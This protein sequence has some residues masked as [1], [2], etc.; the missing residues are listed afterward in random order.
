MA[1]FPTGN[2]GNSVA[3]PGPLPSAPPANP[4]DQAAER[5]GQIAFGV[6]TESVAQETAQQQ[7]LY[8]AGA[9]VALSGAQNQL[10]DASDDVKRRIADGSLSTEEA[11]AEFKKAAAKVRETAFKGYGDQQRL[12]M[13]AHITG[14]EGTIGRDINGAIFKRRQTETASFIDQY[15]EEQS[16][17]AMRDP[18]GPSKATE[19]VRAM[20]GFAGPAAN[21]NPAQQA[22]LGQSFAERVHA[23]FYERAGNAAFMKSDVPSLQAL[24]AQVAGPDGEVLD[25]TKRTQI[26][27][28]LFT[29]EQQIQA[30]AAHG[31]DV[32]DK[33]ADDETTSARKF[34]TEGGVMST[35]YQDRLRMLTKGTRWQ[36]EAEGLIDASI[37][38]AG[39]GSQ[40]VPRQAAMLSAMSG[41]PMSPEQSKDL[42][43]ARTIHEKQTAAYKEDPWDAGSRFQRLPLVAAQPV[44]GVGQLL[45]MAT[46]RVPMMPGLEAA[47]G[48]PAPLLRPAEVPQAIQQLQSASIRERTEVL[49][50]LGS[51]LKPNQIAALADQLE[52]GSKPLALTLKMSTDKTTAG[53]MASEL[54]QVGAQAL[55][56]KTVKRDDSA[57]VG[58]RA[59]IAGLVRGTLGDPKAEDDVI[60]AAY[61]IRAAQ[62]LEGAAAPGF[63][64]PAGA[65]KAVEMVIGKPMDR[66]GVKT[67][68]PK[69]MDESAFDTKMQQLLAKGAGQTVYLRGQPVT[70]EGLANR[71]SSYGMRMVRPGEYMPISGN[72]P[73]TVDKEGQ[74]PL[75][76]RV[77]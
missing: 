61:Y 26:Q 17:I 29:W 50:Q 7:V 44:L 60:E 73:F 67:F 69:G 6:V 5:T 9:A 2:F 62:E 38:G 33:M 36:A 27:H 74:Q 24:R 41:Q 16:R 77:N 39:F 21:L 71:L 51:M 3:R 57:L 28:Q 53:R 19:R 23:T 52:K 75:R 20:L 10:L 35:E 43:H 48:M 68:L 63:K 32:A 1:T 13:D 76:L 56:D 8:R 22:K 37:R 18:G 47:S 46:D 31:K 64:L 42:E 40:T 65:D 4:I 45:K 70:V 15:S 72:A 54:V 34:A 58:W 59:E 14:V 30:K 11:G 55:A 12:E 49:G 66:G 25:P